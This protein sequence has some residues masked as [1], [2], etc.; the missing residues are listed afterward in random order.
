[1]K[2]SNPTPPCVDAEFQNAMPVGGGIKNREAGQIRVDNPSIL[3]FEMN[4][5]APRL[6]LVDG[7]ENPRPQPRSSF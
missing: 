1:M 5:C 2:F 4:S 6:V 7:A 3:R